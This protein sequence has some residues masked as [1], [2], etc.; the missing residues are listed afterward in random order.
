MIKIHASLDSHVLLQAFN[1]NSW[2]THNKTYFNFLETK[3]KYIKESGITGV[4]IP[5]VSRS[6]S[7]QGYMPLDLYN[8]N[9][10]YGTQ[11]EL[12]SLIASF[13]Q[14]DIDVY[15]DIVINHRCAEFQNKEGIYN[16]FGGKMSW[17]DSAIISNDPNFKGKGNAS[18]FKLFEGAPNIDHSQEN[19]RNDI[20]E[21]LM[22]LRNDIGFNGF[23]LDYMTGIN[24]KHIQVYMDAFPNVQ[25]IGEYWDNMNYDVEYLK[26]DQNSHRQDII[27]WIDQSGKQAFAFDITTKG[28]L[29]EAI[30]KN[31]FWRL[32]DSNKKPSGVIGLWSEKSITFLDNHDTHQKSQNLW[33]FLGNKIAGY[34]YILTHPGT[35]MICWDDFNNNDISRDIIAL[36]NIRKTY[37]ITATSWVKIVIANEFQYVAEIDDTLKVYIG[38]SVHESSTN[39]KLFSSNSVCIE[40]MTNNVATDLKTE[41]TEMELQSH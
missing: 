10:E 6:V 19:V 12:K 36:I 17:D 1:W 15:G 16:V 24:P 26:Y 38:N 23:R 30:L 18:H 40:R 5:P 32:A 25:F 22:W 8:L 20:I 28:I 14:H 34:A 11:S 4:W 35:P 3:S 27:D 7:P 33:P 39:E 31:E 13:N 29:Q 2:R 9:S 21:W 37:N 41:S